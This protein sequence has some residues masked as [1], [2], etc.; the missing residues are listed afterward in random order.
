MIESK[1]KRRYNPLTDERDQRHLNFKNYHL[2]EWGWL[3]CW[4]K[5]QGNSISSKGNVFSSMLSSSQMLKN[6]WSHS[7]SLFGLQIHFMSKFCWVIK[8]VLF[9]GFIIYL[10]MLQLSWDY[11]QVVVTFL[12][13]PGIPLVNLGFHW[14][15]NCYLLQKQINTTPSF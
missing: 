1:G 13:R 7:G 10:S 6:Y 15:V 11:M 5:L 12:L 14:P 9:M 4:R 2:L 8:A 3:W